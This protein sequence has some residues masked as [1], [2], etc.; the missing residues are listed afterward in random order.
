M[1]DKTISALTTASA[2]AGTEIFSIAQS[3]ATKKATITEQPNALSIPLVRHR[4]IV[5]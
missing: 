3:F 4:V 5:V 1:A 2:L